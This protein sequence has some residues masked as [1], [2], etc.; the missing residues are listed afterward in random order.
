[1]NSQNTP[2]HCQLSESSDTI[3]SLPG[4]LAIMATALWVTLIGATGTAKSAELPLLKRLTAPQQPQAAKMPPSLVAPEAPEPSDQRFVDNQGRT[5]YSYQFHDPRKFQLYD[6]PNGVKHSGNSMSW[7]Y[8]DANRPAGAPSKA[9]VIAQ[10]QASM[11][12]WSAVCN[13]SFNYAGETTNVP[14]A[15]SGGQPYDGVNVIGWDPSGLT[16]PTT[17]VANVWFF[18]GSNG[19]RGSFVDAD[20][21]LNAAYSVTYTAPFLDGTITHE[22]G[23]AIGLQ[24][25]DVS[26][27]L[28]SGPPLTT[29]DNGRT[30][31]AADDIAGCV[32]LY[33]AVGGA[34]TCTPPQPANEQ[35]VLACPAGQTGAITQQRSYSCVGTT[36]TAGAYA[37]IS[38]TCVAA[39]CTPPQ[40]AAEQ[41]V[42]ACPAG[43]TGAITQQRTYTCVGTTWT[44][45]AYQT[46]SNTC[47]P[48]T[49][50]A[51]QPPPDQLIVGCPAG[52]TGS[53]TQQRTYTCVSGNW[54]PGA[55]QTVTNSCTAI[56]CAGPQPPN[57]SQTLTCPAGQTGSITQQRSY[58]CIAGTWTPGSYATTASTC[59][60]SS[61]P[62]GIPGAWWAGQAENGWGLSLIQHA[63]VLVAGWYYYGNS[64][65]PTWAI[66]PGCNWN[67]SFTTC[68]GQVVA[69]T[70][71]WLGNYS[72]TPFQQTTTGTVTFGFVS[73][74]S[75]TMQWNIGGIPGFKNITK[76]PLGGSGNSPTGVDY[77]DVWWGGQ[78]QNGWGLALAQEGSVLVGAW[79]TYNQQGQPV[80]YLV[81]PGQWTGATTYSTTLLRA[82]GSP[83]IGAV[84]NPALMNGVQAGTIVLNFSSS[85]TGTMTYTVDGVSQSKP[86]AR[87]PF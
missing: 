47:V 41:Q 32:A 26:G 23:H 61:P 55:Y 81:Q 34:P 58:T 8:N 65:Q 37:T 73:G 30:A 17:G 80:W 35:Q 64:G 67:T 39:T 38:N 78:A 11:A 50:A 5:V 59:T 15:G 20:I 3:R 1:M 85:S 66:M 22:V 68:S 27:Q 7:A 28:M 36:W 44:A 6:P 63:N 2:Q 77:T 43:Q 10:I 9:A 74:Q 86:I 71:A 18:G 25:S 4:P 83:L 16:A 40:P 54:T 42:L 13:I 48:A 21:R 72:A 51:P 82:T 76:L 87:L 69:S 12:K 14:N 56:P 79:Y 24:H 49:C 31:L 70:S 60:S 29:Y 62:A 33:G 46:I 52:Q 75:G 84:Y 57:D 45:G 19:Q 53:V